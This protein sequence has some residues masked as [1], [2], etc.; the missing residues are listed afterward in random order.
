MQ[1]EVSRRVSAHFIMMDVAPSA[2]AGWKQRT[3][4]TQSGFF[5]LRKEDNGETCGLEQLLLRAHP[6]ISNIIFLSSGGSGLL[7]AAGSSPE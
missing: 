4:T 1:L 6:D 5:R 2:P 7:E 3:L